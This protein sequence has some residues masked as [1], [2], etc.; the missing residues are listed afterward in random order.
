[1]ILRK[2]LIYKFLYL[3][4]LTFVNGNQLWSY[5][6][7]DIFNNQ[8][9]AKSI[10]L[11]SSTIA[12]PTPFIGV[13]LVNPAIQY[14]DNKVISLT[15]QS[16]LGGLFS[17]ELLSF[18]L[19]R[20]EKRPISISVL[21]Q[22]IGSI[23]DTRN[24]LLDWGEDGVFGTQDK[25][26]GNGI[27]DYDERLDISK[28]TYFSQ[29]QYGLHISQNLQINNFYFGAAAKILY[30]SILNNNGMGIGFDLGLYSY[31]K[32]VHY[33]LVLKNVPLSLLIWNSGTIEK[34]PLSFN[35]GVSKY[36]Q[37]N[38]IKF[39]PLLALNGN[40][41]NIYIE[42]YKLFNIIPFNI[43]F[44]VEIDY[45]ST[46]KIRYGINSFED[47]SGGLGFK[48]NDIVIDYSFFT[49]SDLSKLGNNHLFTI[50]I[51]SENILK[52]FKNK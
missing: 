33:A 39:I 2:K 46:I 23:P 14:V 17:S 6:G 7:W 45:K 3:F 15:H 13:Q 18:N 22:G 8:K 32:S 34:T 9:D 38:N 24:I 52:L 36:F 49:I 26:E 37:V 28:I 19:S 20:G 41:N 44:G 5:Y 4:I 31:K 30:K 25:G 12:F 21:Y 40:L 27:L 10:S 42:S 43:R 11:A 50:Q 47:I 16:H 51:P 35:M 48:Y 29:K 1:M